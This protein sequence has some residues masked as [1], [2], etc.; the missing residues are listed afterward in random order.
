M[1]PNLVK[2]D[3]DTHNYSRGKVVDD[4]QGK[5]LNTLHS[6][7][8]MSCLMHQC[9]CSAPPWRS[10]ALVGKKPK[11][12]RKVQNGPMVPFFQYRSVLCKTKC[13]T[14]SLSLMLTGSYRPTLTAAPTQLFF[15][16]YCSNNG[17]NVRKIWNILIL[18]MWKINLLYIH[19][20][21][22]MNRKT[23]PRY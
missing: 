3:Y 23:R 14:Q 20:N 19:D 17:K 5:H 1:I 6:L 11:G 9:Q 15:G 7:V 18:T 10:P 4:S 22:V 8:D 13:L 16:K 2:S 12:K 21:C